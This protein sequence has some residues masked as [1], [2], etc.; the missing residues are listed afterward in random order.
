[1]INVF[2]SM[3]GKE[4]LAEVKTSIDNQWL[5][6]G[7]KVEKFEKLFTERI[8]QD[9]VLI[10]NCSNGLYLAVQL[11]SLPKGSEVI[12]PAN[13]WVSCATAV[14]LNGCVPVF[15]DCDHDTLNVTDET[16]ADVITVKTKA[17]MVVHYSGYPVDVEEIKRF[18][19][20]I[21][22]DVAHAVDSKVDNTYCGTMGDIGVFSFDSMKNLACGEL[23]GITCKSS[24]LTEKAI[25]S[26]Y[27]GLSKSGLQ[28]ATTKDR[29]WEYDLNGYCFKMLPNDIMASIGL[30][31]LRKLSYLQGKRRAIWEQYQEEIGGDGDRMPP[32]IQHSYFT[33]FVRLNERDELA[34]FLLDNGIYTTVRYQPLHQL[35]KE[36]YRGPLEVAEEF[37]ERGLNLP[38]HP[39]LT[40]KEVDYIIGKVKN[41]YSKTLIRR[42]ALC[43]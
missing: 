19:L 39:N 31:Q 7:P 3:V 13:T 8:G 23:G 22:E 30:A 20:P 26:R 4:E 42:E 12:V 37:G 2:G 34:K 6:M 24:V 25:S 28:N 18:G 35:F 11:L 41:F 38:L 10:D 40:W 33:Y 21:I 16:I 29:W 36:F 15:A 27:C 1:M 14:I 9:F 5:G 32:E 43:Q 17:I